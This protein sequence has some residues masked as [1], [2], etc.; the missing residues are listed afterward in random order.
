MAGVATNIIL[1]RQKFC[2]GKHVFVTT[3]IILV[4]APTSDGVGGAGGGEGFKFE[5]LRA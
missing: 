1:S 3:K 5:L 4:A 2:R